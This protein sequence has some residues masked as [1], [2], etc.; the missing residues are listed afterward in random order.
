MPWNSIS[1]V[2]LIAVSSLVSSKDKGLVE[3]L[4]EPAMNLCK[5]FM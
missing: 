5:H 2:T 1:E 4:L 3:H